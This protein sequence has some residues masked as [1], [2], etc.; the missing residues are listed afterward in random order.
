M[1]T[2]QLLATKCPLKSQDLGITEQLD[3]GIRYLD[4]EVIF[5]EN[6]IPGCNGLETGNGA[7]PIFGVTYHCFGLMSEALQE[8]S[9]WMLWHPTEVVVLRFGEL[10]VSNFLTTSKLELTLKYCV[11]SSMGSHTL[12]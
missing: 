4:F 1:S 5:N 2:P 7:A 11:F 10:Q 3:L 6:N 12:T 8:I 9:D